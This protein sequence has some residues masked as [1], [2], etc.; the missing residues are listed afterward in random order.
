[1]TIPATPAPSKHGHRVRRP[2]TD[3][4][5]D[6]LR[7]RITDATSTPHLLTSVCSS[8]YAMLLAG[9]H[10]SHGHDRTDPGISPDDVAIPRAQW[11]AI[12]AAVT[13]RAHAWGTSIQIG[14]D[15]VNVMPSA[16]DDPAVVAPDLVVRDERA[17]SLLI[18][19]HRDAVDTIRDCE[20]HIQALGAAYGER[21]SQYQDASASWRR[22]VGALFSIGFGARTVVRRDGPLSLYV[23]TAGG[24]VFGIVFHGERRRCTVDG[25]HAVADAAA[26][27][28]VSWRPSSQDTVVLEHEHQ[29]SFPFGAP[30][31]GSWS[32]HS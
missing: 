3:A 20:A 22:Q 8:L 2:L 10:P 7:G 18:E 30:Q 21:S 12:A 13:N 5:L 27:G 24:F 23:S 14:M 16:Y 25:C 26:D 19:V 4:E 6:T 32:S 17:S 1:M 28:T 29:P 15:L 9:V 11:V 31:P